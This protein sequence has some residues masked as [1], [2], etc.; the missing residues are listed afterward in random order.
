MVLTDDPLII[1]GFTTNIKKETQR[2]IVPELLGSNPL[3]GL[4]CKENRCSLQ[5]QASGGVEPSVP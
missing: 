4:P 2:Y 1:M 5:T 3:D